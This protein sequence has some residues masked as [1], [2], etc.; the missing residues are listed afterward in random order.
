MI[1]SPACAVDPA[2]THTQHPLAVAS[3]NQV[4]RP[5]PATPHLARPRGGRSFP[6]NPNTPTES[7]SAH[8]Y[9]LQSI[10]PSLV[11]AG[12][13]RLRNK[14]RVPNPKGE[15]PPAVHASLSRALA[16]M[17]GHLRCTPHCR[18]HSRK[19]TTKTQ[20]AAQFTAQKENCPQRH[21]TSLRAR[22]TL[23]WE[24]THFERRD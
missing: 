1:G 14:T 6:M 19:H 12:R 10:A 15:W 23:K 16:E 18:G 13:C 17:N 8:A 5:L 7:K 21:T 3:Q 20:G 24:S 4:R 9:I 11:P 22:R 2:H